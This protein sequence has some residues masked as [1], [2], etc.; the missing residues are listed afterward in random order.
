MSITKLQLKSI[1]H[2]A[3]LSQETHAFTANIYVNGKKVGQVGNE[4]HGGCD[5]V[6]LDKGSVSLQ[7]LNEYCLSIEPPKSDKDKQLEEKYQFSVTYDFEIWCCEQ[8]NRFLGKKE[9]RSKLKSNIVLIE[10][11]KVYMYRCKPTAENIKAVKLRDNIKQ[12]LN[13]MNFD[14][15]LDAF[16]EV[17]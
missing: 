2:S 16:L 17:A 3:S 10:D 13:E 1:Q 11:G 14:D 7:E 12:V 4:G 5:F 8:V 15:A 6:H 9:L